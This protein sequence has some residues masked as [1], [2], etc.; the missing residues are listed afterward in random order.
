MDRDHNGARGIFLRALGDTVVKK[1][2]FSHMTIVS[3]L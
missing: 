3:L 2:D 1:V